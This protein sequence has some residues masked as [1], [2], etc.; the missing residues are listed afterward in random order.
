[1]VSFVSMALEQFTRNSKRSLLCRKYVFS[2]TADG[3]AKKKRK[4]EEGETSEEGTD[5]ERP[6]KRGRPPR[7]ANKEVIKGFTD[8]ECKEKMRPVKKALKALD[9]PDQTLR[10]EEQVNH[11]RQCL[12]QIGDQI[13]KCLTEYKDPEIIKQWRSNLWY[14]VSKFTEYDPKKLYKLYKHAI[15][16]L[17][18]EK[19]EKEG[20]PKEND[21]IIQEEH[22][23]F[24]I[25]TEMEIEIVVGSMTKEGLL[26]VNTLSFS[27]SLSL[28]P[29]HF[30]C[31]CL[32]ILS[33]D[34]SYIQ[35]HVSEES[36][37]SSKNDAQKC[38]LT[39]DDRY[40]KAF[41]TGYCIHETLHSILSVSH[42]SSPR[43]TR[44]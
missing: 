32:R 40:F 5:E 17:K 18:P 25:V 12:V 9:N 27:L 13:N 28:A 30:Q 44:C 3:A 42:I 14:F 33:Y 26:I 41:K 21:T 37:G 23:R 11:T 34:Y 1:M 6:R 10:P 8:S 31:R 35:A 38:L 2:G 20:I 36:N 39:R 15:R 4:K 7:S 19:E 24:A 29:V 16:K 22:L 43:C